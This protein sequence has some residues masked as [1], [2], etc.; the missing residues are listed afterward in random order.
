M[1]A[2]G[3]AC[4]RVLARAD[5]RRTDLVLRRLVFVPKLYSATT[6]SLRLPQNSNDWDEN[7]SLFLVRSKC[8]G[9]GGKNKFYEFATPK[10]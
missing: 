10:P 6:V 1:S 8:L 2:A 5:V 9:F 7:R 3:G 4:W